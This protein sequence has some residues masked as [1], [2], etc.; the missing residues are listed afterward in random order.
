MDSS[1][2]YAIY[3]LRQLSEQAERISG[4]NTIPV[5]SKPSQIL[6][7]TQNASDISLSPK[8]Q[9]YSRFIPSFVPRLDVELE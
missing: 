6:E 1:P 7:L 5:R 4:I 8:S 3:S 9:Q 2:D